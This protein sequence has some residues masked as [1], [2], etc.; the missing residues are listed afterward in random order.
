MFY[1][2][3]PLTLGNFGKRT[4]YGGELSERPP[5][6][7]RL[8]VE[9]D[10]WP[11]DIFFECSCTYVGTLEVTKKLQARVP[12]ITGVSYEEMTV[13]VGRDFPADK[14][15]EDLPEYRWYKIIGKPGIDDFGMLGDVLVISDEAMTIMRSGM[16]NC[17]TS[18]FIRDEAEATS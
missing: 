9:F 10:K 2:V 5:K 16:P 3:Q 12:R 8:H 7:F 4:L 17:T 1:K 14:K 18:I 13:S 6:I 15:E 11:E